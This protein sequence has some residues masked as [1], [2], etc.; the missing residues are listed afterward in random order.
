MNGW[1]Q[2]PKYL[3]VR[4][5]NRLIVKTVLTVTIL[6]SIIGVAAWLLL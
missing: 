1:S 3:T 2:E 6:V 4:R 5:R